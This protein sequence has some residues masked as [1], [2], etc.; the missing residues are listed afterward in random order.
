MLFEDDN[1][2]RALAES[3]KYVALMPDDFD[4]YYQRAQIKSKLQDLQGAIDD[5]SK[6]IELND[7]YLFAY[8]K[9]ADVYKR[10]MVCYST[11]SAWIA[12]A[13]PDYTQRR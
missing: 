4:G 8:I 9:R 3:N 12:C 13:V 11:R 5:Y 6:G 10:Q 7:T 2:Q 1:F